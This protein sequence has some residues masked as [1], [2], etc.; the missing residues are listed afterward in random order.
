MLTN[1]IGINA[2]TIWKLL[3]QRGNLTVREI[4]ELTHYKDSLIML[5]LG[6]LSRESKIEF[7]TTNGELKIGL[8]QV[9]SDLYY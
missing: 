7:S 1:D 3:S 6:W 8:K 5:A 9:V 2:G 4:G